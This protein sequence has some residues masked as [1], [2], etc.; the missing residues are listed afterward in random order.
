MVLGLAAELTLKAS[1]WIIEGTYRGL[2]YLWYGPTE[3]NEE[4]IIRE[5]EALHKDNMELR[6]A[7]KEELEAKLEER[8]K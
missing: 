1:F 6:K 5:L 2:S 4:K 7:L 8:A 3:T